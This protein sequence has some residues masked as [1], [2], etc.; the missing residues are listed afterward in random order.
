MKTIKKFQSL[1]IEKNS[2][3]SILGG[4][5]SVPTSKNSDGLYTDIWEDSNNDGTYGVGDM[6]CAVEPFA[7]H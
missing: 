5:N 1:E 7:I 3:G 6:I 4:A 2:L